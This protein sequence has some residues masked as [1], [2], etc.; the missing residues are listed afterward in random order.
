MIFYALFV[1]VRK[2]F[3]GYIKGDSFCDKKIVPW[4]EAHNIE[5]ACLTFILE[6]TLDFTFWAFIS[7]FYVK[8]HGIGKQFSDLFSN[9]LAFVIIALLA[10]APVHLLIR[11]NQHIKKIR[12]EKEQLLEAA[13]E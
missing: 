10:Y 6:G 7:V 12:K 4:F 11:G 8:A 1:G 13:K 3:T 5:V 2:I 9:L